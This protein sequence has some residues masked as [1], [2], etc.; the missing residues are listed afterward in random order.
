MRI[1]GAD[2]TTVN[3]Q[4]VA[5]LRAWR[6]RVPSGDAEGTLEWAAE[7]FGGRIVLATSFGAED[8]VLTHLVTTRGLDIPLITLDTGRLFPETY[9]LIAA[10]ERRYGIRTRVL[11]PRTD[12]VER[13]V[14]AHGVDLFRD[15]R[16]ER[17]LCCRVRKME[18]LARGLE[19][20]EAWVTGLRTAQ[21]VTRREVRG[22]AWDEA[23]GLVKVSPLAGWSEE[24]VWAFVREHDVPV[25]PLHARGFPSIGCAPCTRAIAPGEDSRS[26][27][28]WWES[29]EDRECG[30]HS[31]S[32]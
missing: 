8:Q 26:G 11:F 18:P 25:S 27:R 4:L 17:K 30:L 1:S 21:S 23:H 28:W 9:E 20:R 6:E 19:G 2:R 31:G 13:M 22:V 10:T 29:A 16:A 24:D 3:H 14:A 12:D 15:G 5:A 7:H 32:G